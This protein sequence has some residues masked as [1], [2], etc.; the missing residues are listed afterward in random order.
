MLKVIVT[1]T[2]GLIVGVVG[3]IA[4]IY[5]QG[6]TTSGASQVGIPTVGP[7]TTVSTPSGGGTGATTGTKPTNP[8]TGGNAATGKTLFAANGCAA[9]HTFAP[10]GASGT[11]GP[12][13]ADAYQ[14]A[15]ADGNVPLDAYLFQSIQDPNAYITS[16]Y[17]AN[18]M[19]S[20]TFSKSLSS[21][22]IDDLV[23]FLASGQAGK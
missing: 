23:A 19:P 21:Q 11:V 8:G 22:Q 12:N 7:A 2:V 16:G 20:T 18:I 9:C 5:W 3:M 6:T 14:S 17:S 10:A 1:A 13:L 4:L 15:K